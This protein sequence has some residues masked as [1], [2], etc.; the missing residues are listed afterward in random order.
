MKMD[1]VTTGQSLFFSC[2]SK[3]PERIMQDKK[4]FSHLSKHGILYRKQ[5]GFVQV[6]ADEHATMQL[7]DQMNDNFQ[8]YCFTLDILIDFH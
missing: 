4:L 3:I 5:F 1:F 2:F 7:I 8:S 6:Y